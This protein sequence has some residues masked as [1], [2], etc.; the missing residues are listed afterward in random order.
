MLKHKQEVNFNPELPLQKYYGG[1][2]L[3]NFVTFSLVRIIT[4]KY[5]PSVI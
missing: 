3:T 4:E 5:I 2:F 1:N